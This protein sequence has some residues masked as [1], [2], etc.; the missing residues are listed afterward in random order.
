MPIR[1]RHLSLGTLL[2]LILTACGGTTTPSGTDPGATSPALTEPGTTTE[3]AYPEPL[4]PA[5]GATAYPEPVA[6]AAEVTP[7][8]EPA[9]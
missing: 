5:E 6:P 9:P 7:Y 4:A 8:P 2:L 1:I 3:T